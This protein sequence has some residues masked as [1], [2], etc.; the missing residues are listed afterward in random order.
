MKRP[1]ASESEL[2]A[3]VLAILPR[4]PRLTAPERKVV[5]RVQNAPIPMV[6][7]ALIAS[8][9]AGADPLG[10]TLIALRTPEIR[11]LAGPG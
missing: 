8:I 6:P 3:T 9:A 7:E 5:A 10:E 11:R 2:L 1:F 4:K